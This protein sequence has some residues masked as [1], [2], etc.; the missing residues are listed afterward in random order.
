MLKM[1]PGL[2]QRSVRAKMVTLFIEPSLACSQAK[3]SGE[4]TPA[5]RKK[6]FNSCETTP[7]NS[8]K[9]LNTCRIL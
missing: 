7:A 4:T 9:G 5:N 8:K 3:L 2:V 1:R 6:G